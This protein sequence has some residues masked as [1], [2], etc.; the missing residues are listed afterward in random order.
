MGHIRTLQSYV[1]QQRG[2]TT[3][4]LRGLLSKRLEAELQQKQKDLWF[5]RENVGFEKPM[6]RKYNMAAMPAHGIPS[7]HLSAR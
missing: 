1:V 7:L 5:K 2:T 4:V 3:T 6:G